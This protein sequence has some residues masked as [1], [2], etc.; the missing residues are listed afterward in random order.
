MVHRLFIIA[1]VLLKAQ[2]NPITNLR[3]HPEAATH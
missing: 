3:F 2:Q 1:D